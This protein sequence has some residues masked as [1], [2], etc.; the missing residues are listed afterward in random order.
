MNTHTVYVLTETYDSAIADSPLKGVFPSWAECMNGVRDELGNVEEGMVPSIMF[1]FNRHLGE[2]EPNSAL[3]A[4]VE[5]LPGQFL[6]VN[7]FEVSTM[8]D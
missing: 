5:I 4:M 7:R 3:L 1:E 8:N 2:A 6:H